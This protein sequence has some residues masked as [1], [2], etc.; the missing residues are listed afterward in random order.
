[1]KRALPIVLTGVAAIVLLGG[2]AT[3]NFVRET[4]GRQGTEL[5]QKIV[6]VENQ[7]QQERTRVSRVEGQVG[8]Q[9]QRVTKVETDVSQRVEGMGFRVTG[10]ER[11]VADA[12]DTAKT[13]LN[14]AESVDSRV[15]RMVAGRYKKN[16]VDTVN[17][18]FAFD[19]SELSDNA[20]TALL[21][22]VKE[23]QANAGLTVQLEGYT[24]PSGPRDHNLALSQRRVDSVRRFLVAHGIE[25]PRI[26]SVGL[27]PT[28][29]GSMRNG[30]K[31]RVLVK[32]MTDSD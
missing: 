2:C 5:D 14:K 23:L 15:N 13:A 21:S 11:S 7:V 29:D 19:R 12:G 31:R 18:P 8:E 25:L 10:L 22:V 16:I 3:K 27:G 6:G 26:Y 9:A 17:I 30:E 20:Q 24:D 4:V 28:S 1:M 32:L